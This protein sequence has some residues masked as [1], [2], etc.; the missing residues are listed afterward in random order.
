MIFAQYASGQG[1]IDYLV[2]LTLTCVAI[3]MGL[4]IV[5]QAYRGYRRNDSRRMLF[6]A[7]GLALLT[8]VPFVLSLV[9]AGVGQRFGFESRVYTSYLPI[10]NRGLEICGLSAILYSLYTRN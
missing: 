7:I 10:V 6:L 2:L 4:Y 5:F 8:I 3:V 1:A 9:V